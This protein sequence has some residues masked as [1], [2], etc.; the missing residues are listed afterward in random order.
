MLLG[1]EITRIIPYNRDVPSCFS[2]LQGRGAPASRPLMIDGVL[3]S[4]FYLFFCPAHRG[5]VPP[6]RGAPPLCPVTPGRPDFFMAVYAVVARIPAG[7]VATYGLVAFLA[8]RPRASRIVGCALAR[9]PEGLPCH[10]VLYRDGG[11][12]PADVFGGTGIQRLL[13][14]G[15]GVPFLPDGRVD[16]SRCLWD[17]G[18]ERSTL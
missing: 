4:V 6:K 12:S 8:G 1:L 17:G 14:E 5:A 10:R 11:L 9:A 3:V 16:L 2:N 15:E 7:Q 18:E 13:L